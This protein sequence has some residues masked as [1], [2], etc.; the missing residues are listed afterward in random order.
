MRAYTDLIQA[1]HHMKWDLEIS[2]RAE[3]RGD[4]ETEYHKQWA[5]KH[6]AAWE[7]IR[8][9]IDVGE[10]LYSPVSV[11]ILQELDG[12]SSGPD[13]TYIDHLE[14]L[15]AAVEKCLPAIKAAARSDLGLPSIG[16]R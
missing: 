5:A 3:M 16:P 11:R 13:D 7:E 6:K 15:Q 9:Q 8:K 10:F 12:A 14:S 4:E 2:I 1:L